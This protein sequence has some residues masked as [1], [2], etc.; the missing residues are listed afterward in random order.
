MKL[1]RVTIVTGDRY[2]VCESE[3]RARRYFND[4]D[5]LDCTHIAL[6]ISSEISD[7]IDFYETRYD[8]L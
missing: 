3:E 2:I 6:Q 5:I 4:F 1:F 7:M 8:Y